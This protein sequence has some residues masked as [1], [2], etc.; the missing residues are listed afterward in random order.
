LI[1]MVALP[2]IEGTHRFDVGF[3]SEFR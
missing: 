1:F 3:V 2:V